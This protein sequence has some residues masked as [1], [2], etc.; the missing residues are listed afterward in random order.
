MIVAIGSFDGYHIGH[1]LLLTEARSLAE[2]VGTTWGVVTFSPYPGCFFNSKQK[3]LFTER[4]KT[5]ISK[6]LGVPKVITIR[7]DE[8][9]CKM[10]YLEFLSRLQSDF[11]VN[12]IVVGDDFKMGA[13]AA[14]NLASIAA[15][16]SE[17]HMECVAVKSAEY[18]R[19]TMGGRKLSA[20]LLRSWC[21]AGDIAKV[22]RFLGFPLPISGT[23]IHGEG[24]GNTLGYPTA[25]ISVAEDKVLPESGIFAASTFL[26][27][28][29]RSGAVFIGGSPT[30]G[31]VEQHNVEVHISD[32]WGDLYN[33]NI[34]IFLEDHLRQPKKY[35]NNFDLVKSITQSVRD[36][37]DIFKK[38]YMN[39]KFIYDELERA[40]S[41]H[42]E[43]NI[44][45]LNESAQ[46]VEI[47]ESYKKSYI[48]LD[49]SRITEIFHP[50]FI[51]NLNCSLAEAIVRPGECTE[52]HIHKDSTEIYYGL[53]GSGFF[54][55]YDMKNDNPEKTFFTAGTAVLIK[56]GTKH[57]ICANNDSGGIPLRFL[58]FC[59]PPYTHE[60]TKLIE[61]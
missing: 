2:K 46:P 11:G 40:F 14:G 13:G 10:T 28:K 51:K 19:A 24:R 41:G 3:K 31:S 50:N 54:Y 5:A 8:A 20:T 49:K 39:S 57:Y 44:I 18:N 34:T 16:C 38:N 22:R 58:C 1:R 52:K 7:F 15:F 55:I 37:E 30:F 42:L 53:E 9:L 35:D 17:H 12:G 25:N 36:S 59:T 6:F 32:F 48:T 21:E 61:T 33:R 60:Q 27:G 4:E 29:W 56:S 45:N 26:D 23:V 43:L 47:D